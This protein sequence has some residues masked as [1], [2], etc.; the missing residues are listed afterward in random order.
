MFLIAGI[1]LV[2]SFA[3]FLNP[4]FKTAGRPAFIIS[5]YLLSFGDIVLVTEVA[6]LLHTMSSP[7]FF[8]SAHFFLAL[9]AWLLW[10]RTGKPSLLGPFSNL[11]QIVETGKVWSSIKSSPELWILGSAA[12]CAYGINA[13]VITK[14][15]P[16]TY[17]SMTCHMSRVG[18]WLQ[19]GSMSPWQTPNILQTIYPINAQSGFFWTILLGGSDH[20]V[21]FV[22]WL[23]VPASMAAIYGIARTFGVTRQQALFAAL[24]WATFPQ[25]ILQSTS[26]Q[27]DLVGAA[28]MVSVLYFLFT[29]LKSHHRGDLVLSGLAFGLALGTK[30]TVFFLVPG[31]VLMMVMVWLQRRG[32]VIRPFLTWTAASAGAF[33]LVGCYIY[34]LNISSHG[35][36]FG[37]KAL[38]N[39]YGGETPP[40]VSRLDYFVINSFRY[41]YQSI[42]FTGLP[43]GI[44]MPLAK[45]KADLAN[46][47]F[48]FLHIPINSPETTLSGVK[49]NLYKEPVPHEDIAWFGPLGILLLLPLSIYQFFVALLRKDFFKLGL[50]LMAFSLLVFVA[51]FRGGWTPYQGR[52]FVL[53]TALCAP[54]LSTIRLNGYM[55]SV[56]RWCIIPLAII[57]LVWTTGLNNLKPLLGPRK[58]LRIDRVSKLGLSNWKFPP[59]LEMV[60]QLVPQDATL[61][62]I[63]GSDD[64]DYPLFG[65]HFSR[66]IVQI[67]PPAKLTDKAW[68]NEQEINFVVIDTATVPPFQIPSWLHRIGRVQGWSVL[69]RGEPDFASWDKKLKDSLLTFDRTISMRIDNSLNAIIGA[70]DVIPPDGG[71]EISKTFVRLGD[72]PTE[73]VKGV[74]MCAQ[75]QTVQIAFDI[76]D[77]EIPKQQQVVELTVDNQEGRQ[78]DYRRIV[79]PQNPKFTILLQPGENFYRLSVVEKINAGKAGP[80]KS[81]SRTLLLHRIDVTPL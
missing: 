47:I 6:S 9:L 4:L 17:D 5:V 63:I 69:Y 44:A 14:M 65:E 55:R 81:E 60:N 73:G 52:Y 10:L 72:N 62:T 64:W 23:A 56:M 24:I 21:G 19:H 79:P 11:R 34:V 59:V 1:F 43:Y 15:P 49:F 50:I 54:F 71:E 36:M 76:E 42:D 66:R 22:Q 57:I 75:K 31:F 30:Q 58:I 38:V 7:L 2:L 68:M 35:H 67:F 80:Q 61:G 39:Q 28:L 26:T 12:F 32:E 40:S 27:N 13:I 18:Y 77:I 16:N 74:F 51:C 29:G 53:A 33:L 37:P 70:T 46:T 3:L 48:S 45:F 41:F 25:I 8:L 20:F 78:T